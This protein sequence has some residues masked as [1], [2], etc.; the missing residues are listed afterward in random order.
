MS[1]TEKDIQ[2][3]VY[4]HIGRCTYMGKLSGV[5]VCVWLRASVWMGVWYQ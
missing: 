4:G 2:H 1:V 5:D 3:G